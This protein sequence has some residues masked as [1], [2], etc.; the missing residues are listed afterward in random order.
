M[1]A[2]T[3]PTTSSWTRSCPLQIWC[4]GKFVYTGHSLITRTHGGA[5]LIGQDSGVI[6]MDA[7]PAPFVTTVNIVGGTKQFAHA[8]GQYVATGQLDFITGQA[9]GMYTSNVCK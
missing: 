4:P 6:F 1:G 9:V 8:S 3:R 7:A 5:T 2:T